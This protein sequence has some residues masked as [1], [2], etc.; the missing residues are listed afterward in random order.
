MGCDVV[1]DK[2]SQPLWNAVEEASPRGY[3]AIMDANGVATFQESYDHLCPTGRLIIFGFHSNLPMG[4]SVLSPIEWV[5]MAVKG[6]AMPKFDPMD[7]VTAN[8]SVP[9]FN[10]SFF[11][12]ESEVI[13]ELFEILC[14]WLEGG[15][16][17]CPRVTEMGFGDVRGVRM[18]CCRVGRVWARL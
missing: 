9:A 17:K 14:G 6:S 5:K 7:I 18:G 1:I 10:L 3:A 12:E 11:A 2:S 13:G 8:K 16:L 4:R 15:K